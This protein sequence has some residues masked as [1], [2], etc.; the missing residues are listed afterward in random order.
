LILSTTPR[1]SRSS[2]E[3]NPELGLSILYGL[4]DDELS[5]RPTIPTIR[6]RMA[7][8][9]TV[10]AFAASNEKRALEILDR[11]PSTSRF[12]VDV[13]VAQELFEKKIAGLPDVI[14]RARDALSSPVDDE[15]DFVKFINLYLRLK[16][17]D[18]VIVLRE[19]IHEMDE[20]R[21]KDPKNLKLGES[22]YPPIDH[23]LAP[24]NLDSAITELEH[25]DLRAISKDMHT[26]SLRSCFQLSLLQ[27]YLARYKSGTS[28]N[29]ATKDPSSNYAAH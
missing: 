20:W 18:S 11:T 3:N 7:I 12:A 9:A 21:P 22:Y 10:S 16:R 19:A 29:L 4:T 8:R 6:N 5:I 1:G 2:G 24:L 17:P 26:V 27:Q 14:T 28:T 25:A 23:N 15:G 13:A